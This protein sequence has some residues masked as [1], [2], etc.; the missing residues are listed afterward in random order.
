MNIL[1]TIT[2]EAQ[3]CLSSEIILRDPEELGSPTSYL[4]YNLAHQILCHATNY[5]DIWLGL[6][7]ARNSV[8]KPSSF[9]LVMNFLSNSPEI[10]LRVDTFVFKVAKRLKSYLA[11]AS[12]YQNYGISRHANTNMGMQVIEYT[13]APGSSM[14]KLYAYI[15]HSDI[16]SLSWHVPVELEDASVRCREPRHDLVMLPISEG[17]STAL[18]VLYDKVQEAFD[19]HIVLPYLLEGMCMEMLYNASTCIPLTQL[20]QQRPIQNILAQYES[21]RHLVFQT[22]IY[23]IEQLEVMLKKATPKLVLAP[24]DVQEILHF[25]EIHH[26]DSY[27]QRLSLPSSLHKTLCTFLTTYGASYPEEL[28]TALRICKHGTA[29]VQLYISLA[30]ACTAALAMPARE[31]SLE[32]QQLLNS[33]YTFFLYHHAL[34]ASYIDDL[35]LFS[36]LRI[37]LLVYDQ[38]YLS[39]PH[40]IVLRLSKLFCE[41]RPTSP[42]NICLFLHFLFYYDPW[43][44]N[45]PV[46]AG[47]PYNERSQIWSQVLQ[48]LPRHKVVNIIFEYLPTSDTDIIPLQSLFKA[49]RFK[50]ILMDFS[51]TNRNLFIE[52]E[53]EECLSHYNTIFT[54]TY[55]HATSCPELYTGYEPLLYAYGSYDITRIQLLEIFSPGL[56]NLFATMQNIIHLLTILEAD[57]NSVYQNDIHTLLTDLPQEALEK[58]PTKL[59]Y[60][61]LQNASQEYTG[62]ILLETRKHFIMHNEEFQFDFIDRDPEILIDQLLLYSTF[63][64]QGHSLAI[65][66]ASMLPSMASLFQ[67]KPL[68]AHY[69]WNKL[70]KVA[71]TLILQE[72]L[73]QEHLTFITAMLELSCNLHTLPLTP[74]N[75]EAAHAFAMTFYQSHYVFSFSQEMIHQ[76]YHSLHRACNDTTILNPDVSKIFT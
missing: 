57:L 75:L 71:N 25:M 59:L 60:L 23:R 12:C 33:F 24:Q 54:N 13:F 19:D 42:T 50:N 3:R 73:S 45:S 32:D 1:N 53:F 22:I 38:A 11:S 58:T 6:S 30:I 9:Q 7:F 34:H 18:E 66:I 29:H 4:V 36:L 51:Q 44:G 63:I 74:E 16:T 41:I 27:V 26:T 31:L 49:G 55:V 21:L 17:R 65:N 61:L 37:H 56:S 40:N 39:I 69:L 68:Q 72:F 28:R 47:L 35:A 46:F 10:D 5:R 76:S 48:D 20:M 52:Y 67:S 15:F 64:E 2:Q 8:H 14:Q 43:Y 62:D 70:F